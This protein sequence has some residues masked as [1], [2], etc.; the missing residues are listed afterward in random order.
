MNQL[1]ALKKENDDE[2]NQLERN[3]L[4]GHR[5]AVTVNLAG[6]GADD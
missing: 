4:G 6:G 3:Y 2:S 1:Y 5:W